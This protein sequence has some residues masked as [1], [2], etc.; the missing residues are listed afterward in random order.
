MDTS[1]APAQ[2]LLAQGVAAPQHGPRPLPL[3]LNILW[4][5]TEGDPELRKRAFVGLRRYQQAK[6][7]AP[8]TAP[9][10]MVQ[11]G[12]ARLLRYG[13]ENG[14][15]PVVFV[16]SLIN[17]P[18]VLDLSE[19]RSLL[20]HMAAA[21]HDAWLV[22]WGAPLADDRA[23]GLEGHVIDRLLP[24]IAALPRPPIIVGYCL[25][26]TLAMGAA[27][28]RPVQAV[29]TIASP[30]RFDGFADAD[31]QEINALWRGAKPM[32]DRLGYVPMEVLQSGFWAMDPA[33][34][35]R[36]FA[37]FADAAPGSDG[38]R[39]FMAVEDW[40]NGGPPLT[41]A[42]GRD[43]FDD[44]Y[45]GNASGQGRWTVGGQTVDPQALTCP[46]LSIRST[47]D[48]IVPAAASAELAT[49]WQL[50]LG[51]VGMVVGGQARE[52]L[53]LPLSQWLSSHGG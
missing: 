17:P 5:E 45:A 15:A 7:P 31:R 35:I 21:G 4:R 38:E 8:P 11:V 20:R 9:A 33:R 18:Q 10:S 48:R 34:T 49:D 43:L 32:C 3:F 12:S 13:V 40:A 23:M 19:R 26:G 44:L 25:G 53:W 29:A 42:A 30:W 50:K 6:R 51:H 28:L 24:L 22:D 36:K 2:S 46:T 1:P 52:T 39:A 37:V 14:R 47:T 16:P 41:F 27:M